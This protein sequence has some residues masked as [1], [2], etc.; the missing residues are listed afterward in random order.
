MHAEWTEDLVNLRMELGDEEVISRANKLSDYEM[1]DRVDMEGQSLN[2][3][4]AKALAAFAATLGS[5]V[6]IHNGALK[7]V[8][9]LDER[10]RSVVVSEQNARDREVAKQFYTDSICPE[11]KVEGQRAEKY[12]D[13]CTFCQA[14]L[15]WYP[16]G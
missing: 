6:L 16:Y 5:D 1:Y 3:A 9:N 11:C 2:P 4:Q 10:C 14:Q 15:P 8:K 12:N 13:K 7:R